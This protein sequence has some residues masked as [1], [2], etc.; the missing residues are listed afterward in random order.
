MLLYYSTAQ[1]ALKYIPTKFE[2]KQT[3][4]ANLHGAVGRDLTQFQ[5]IKFVIYLIVEI[6]FGFI[7]VL[8]IILF[9][10]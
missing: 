5:L 8:Q 7:D 6:K 4:S 9:E 1:Y 2:N 3:S 10:K